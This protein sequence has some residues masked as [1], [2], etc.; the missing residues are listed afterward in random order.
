MLI[1]SVTSLFISDLVVHVD[2][3]EL[4]EVCE[5]DLSPIHSEEF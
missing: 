3:N 2:L 4:L 1:F 5:I